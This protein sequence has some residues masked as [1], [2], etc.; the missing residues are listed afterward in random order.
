MTRKLQPYLLLA[1][2]QRLHVKAEPDRRYVEV[3]DAHCPVCRGKLVFIAHDTKRTA[4]CDRSMAA[5]A[6]ETLIS[7]GARDVLDVTEPAIWQVRGENPD[8]SDDYN[9]RAQ[10]KCERCRSYVGTLV[11]PVDTLFGIREDEAILSGRY[12]LVIGG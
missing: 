1:D 7:E 5:V 8:K 12:G 3:P 9:I 6:M 11:Q 4:I 2:K 10:A